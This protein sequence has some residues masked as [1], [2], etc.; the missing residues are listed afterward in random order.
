MARLS[1]TRRSLSAIAGHLD[2]GR[3]EAARAKHTLRGLVADHGRQ[4]DAWGAELLEGGDDGV[5][6]QPADAAAPRAGR[7]EDI[8]QRAVRI[9]KQVPVATFERSVRI[10]EDSPRP[11][12]PP[13]PPPRLGRSRA[14]ATARTPLRRAPRG[15]SATGPF[16][17]ACARARPRAARPS[18]GR[19]PGHGG[20]RP[21][22]PWRE[23]RPAA[24]IVPPSESA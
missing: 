9:E 13:G 11:E 1:R 15:E 8:V 19:P 7:D 5:D 10:P 20:R 4:D 16:R 12:R 18:R 21:S 6:E 23:R 3:S 17:G 22:R 2:H 14:R 24:S